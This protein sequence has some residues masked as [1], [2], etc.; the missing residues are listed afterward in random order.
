MAMELFGAEIGV[1]AGIAC[2]VSYLCSGH[3]GIYRSQRVGQAKHRPLPE[4]LKLGELPA[5]RQQQ[6]DSAD[7]PRV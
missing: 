2:V 5:Y 7:K 4:E 6:K 1:Y 3:S